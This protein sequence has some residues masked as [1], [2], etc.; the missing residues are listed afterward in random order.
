MKNFLLSLALVLGFAVP[1]FAS[2]FTSVE[3]SVFLLYTKDMSGNMQFDCTATA[4][5]DHQFLTASHCVTISRGP[6][7]I[8]N[9]AIFYL[10][11]DG[12][13]STYTRAEVI[14]YG[15][16]D[17][18][19]DFALL[20][21]KLDA[22]AAKL[23]DEHSCAKG[24]DVFNVSGAAGYGIQF[25]KGYVSSTAIDRPI[26]SPEEHINWN[27]YMGVIMHAAGGAS[28]SAI[29]NQK[30]EIIGILVGTIGGNLTV[31]C[32]IS[33]FNAVRKLLGEKHSLLSAPNSSSSPRI[34]S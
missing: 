2:Q 11:D 24:D 15:N 14:G 22:P 18:G 1:S 17:E 13:D 25:F 32:P 30:G 23:G 7:L 29:L 20:S 19:M 9:P 12:A 26:A 10:T 5:G 34:K 4:I 21:S 3:K 6:K 27:G 31:A 16:Q 33:R 28:G 8:V